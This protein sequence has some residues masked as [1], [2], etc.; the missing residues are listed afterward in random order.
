MRFVIVGVRNVHAVAGG[1]ACGAT[2]AIAIATVIVLVKSI[3]VFLIDRVD[4]SVAEYN[5]RRVLRRH[6]PTPHSPH[7]HLSTFRQLVRGGCLVRSVFR[8]SWTRAADD[9]HPLH[10]LD[11]HS[12]PFTLSRRRSD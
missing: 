12:G 6:L 1:F 4:D 2:E 5:I 3:D 9:L 11:L 10:W 7:R 8:N